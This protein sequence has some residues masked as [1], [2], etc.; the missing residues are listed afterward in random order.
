MVVL[1]GIEYS[2]QKAAFEKVMLKRAYDV[3]FWRLVE[4]APQHNNQVIFV[5]MHQPCSA[6][7]VVVLF[8]ILTAVS[9]L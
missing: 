9:Q 4:P 1:P 7:R 2:R 8:A 5:I 6:D 3:G